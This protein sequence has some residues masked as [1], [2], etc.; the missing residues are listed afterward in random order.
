MDNMMYAVDQ[1]NDDIA[2]LENLNDKNKEYININ[3]LKFSIREGDILRKENDIFYKD[4]KA[5]IERIKRIQEKFNR[6]KKHKK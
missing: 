4:N 2:L 3:D 6:L 5:K 1:I